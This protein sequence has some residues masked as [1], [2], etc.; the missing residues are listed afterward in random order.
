MERILDF[1]C[2]CQD[3]NI[4]YLSGKSIFAV[5][6]L[7]NLLRATIA[8]ADTESPQSLHTLFGTYLNHMLANFCTFWT[9]QFCSICMVQNVQNCELLTKKRVFDNAF[10]LS[11]TILE[12]KQLRNT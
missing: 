2:Q 8:N 4:K 1:Q 10:T 7:L 12:L 11:K 3:G 5:N 9:I 6:L